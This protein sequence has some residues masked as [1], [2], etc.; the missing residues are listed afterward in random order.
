MDL[1]AMTLEE[2]ESEKA[3]L[4]NEVST[5][6]TLDSA[7][8]VLV[9]S[10]YGALGNQYFRFYDV[11]LAS[12]ITLSGQAI[13]Q[14]IENVINDYGVKLGKDGVPAIK[15]IAGDTDSNYLDLT[16]LMKNL[17]NDTPKEKMVDIVDKFCQDKLSKVIADGMNDI[18]KDTNAK[19]VRLYMKR[20]SIASGIIVA[21]KRFAF[22]VYDMEG[23]R[24]A[25]PDQKITGLESQR[26]STPKWCRDKLKTAYKIFFNGT[27]KELQSFV[28]KTYN[29]YMVEELS[30]LTGASS[31]NNMGKY[32]V[33]GVPIKGTPFHIKG[34]AAYN[35]LIE[36]KGLSGKY[37]LIQ[38]GDKI[39]VVALNEPNPAKAECIAFA[40]KI[41]PEFGI[42]Q[43]VDRFGMF[44]KFFKEPLQRIADVVGWSCEKKYTL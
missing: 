28:K 30:N 24:Y 2:L 21:K 13:I 14:N 12:A 16:N 6:G 35:A 29:E 22:E 41:P 1:S 38:S 44:D 20:E 9:N 25:T 32:I 4:L 37:P 36:K 40:D 10:L 17:P 3:R 8:K 23:V 5:Y 19:V 15:V 39:K 26:S 31:A 27:E 33:D 43:F 34:A 18:S 7:Y 11:N 42:E